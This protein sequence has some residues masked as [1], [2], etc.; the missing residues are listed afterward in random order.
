MD[1]YPEFDVRHR[2]RRSCYAQRFLS[3]FHPIAGGH[4][5]HCV[6]SQH[7]VAFSSSEAGLREGPDLPSAWSATTC[8]RSEQGL[9]H[10]ARVMLRDVSLSRMLMVGFCLELNGRGLY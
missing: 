5:G 10:A 4:P 9:I 2:L 6:D 3:L 7:F 1:R 8:F